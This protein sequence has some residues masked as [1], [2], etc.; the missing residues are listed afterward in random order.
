MR[1]LLVE[2]DTSVAEPLVDGLARYGIVTE[3]V[4][5][6][7]AALA[8]PLTDMVLLA[9]GLPD[10]DGA[11]VCRRLRRAGSVPLIMLTARDDA[12]RDRGVG[13]D[14]YLAKPFS[15]S[16]LVARMREVG[17]R[18]RPPAEDPVRRCGP[19]SV[20]PRTR[21]VRLHKIPIP[22]SPKEFDLLRLL[23]EDPGAVVPR[24]HLVDTIWGPSFAGPGKTLDFHIASL[25]RKLGDPAWVENRRGVG[26]RLVVQP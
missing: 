21:V 13:A 3:H 2:D 19:L 17:R 1:V 5:T 4:V 23:T 8:A 24:R 12:A 20:D 26:F 11:E 16:E 6:G 15:V 7:A 14:D 10:I 18:S 22:L 25:R 9:P